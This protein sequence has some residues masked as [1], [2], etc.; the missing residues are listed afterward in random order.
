MDLQKYFYTSCFVVNVIFN[1]FKYFK[2]IYNNQK[3]GNICD[4]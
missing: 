4:Y 3:T 1:L 2:L